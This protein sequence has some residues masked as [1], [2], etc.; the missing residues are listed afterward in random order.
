MLHFLVPVLF[1]F[2]MQDVLKFKRKFRR[3]RVNM[4]HAAGL[5]APLV[6]NA[7][8]TTC[9]NPERYGTVATKIRTAERNIC[10]FAVR[11]L[12]HV[13]HLAPRILMWV[14]HFFSRK[15]YA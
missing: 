6:V 5:N 8:T 14:L 11:D 2:Y 3:Q 12:F 13:I 1:T 7:Y 10:R 9:T 4:P 15:T